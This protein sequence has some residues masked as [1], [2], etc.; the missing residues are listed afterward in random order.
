MGRAPAPG[1]GL[2]ATLVM[3]E[4]RG[5]NVLDA[6]GNRYV[7]LAAGFGAL[8]L[9]HAHPSVTAAV[10]RQARTLVQALGD[11]YPSDLKIALLERITALYPGPAQAILAQS[12]SDAV[13]A[14][15]K[16]AALFT[17]KPGL[18]AFSGAYH[19]LGYGPLAACGLRAS[20]REPFAAQLNPHVSF[21]DYPSDERALESVLS[22]I[23]QR[24]ASG[25]V[26][27]ILVEP[28]LGRGGVVVPPPAFLPAL[29]RLAASAGALLIADEIWTGLGRAGAW[30]SS[31]NGSVP[32]LFCLGKGLGG[33]LPV[34]AV[35]GRKE[36]M[37]SWQRANEVVH[38]A[39]FSG[40]PLAAAAALATLDTLEKE[41]LVERSARVGD[42]L[43]AD[44]ILRFRAA[45]LDVM[46]R[47]AGLMLGVDLGDR[48][49]FGSTLQER[50]LTHGYITSTGGGRREVLVLTPPL[51]IEQALLDS[52]AEVLVN[53]L[54]ELY[55][56]KP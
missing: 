23:T 15:L 41:R 11:V 35:V 21:V 12:G 20:Y 9:G 44:L 37:A 32:D 42:A 48:P 25:S 38:T 51:D 24:L 54:L 45:G 31:L 19:G 28:I 7:D 22:A 46:V 49:G 55:Q 34:S 13:S 30:L 3:A 27:A 43:R 33:G 8:L 52:F 1:G 5:A 6:D 18:I 16:T 4:A 29:A 10:E 14:A 2:P 40:A 50:L 36:V 17:G 39:T 56:G 47:G 26:G 53:T